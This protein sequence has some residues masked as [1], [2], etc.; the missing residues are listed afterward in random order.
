MYLKNLELKGF[1][2]YEKTE[3]L[4]SEGTNVFLGE[5]AQGKTNLMESIYFL[6][7]ARSHRT[8]KDKEL[9][10]WNQDFARV[11][12]EV[13]TRR[14][15]YPLNIVLS[16]KGK[17]AKLNHLEQKRLS[18]YIGHLN[19]ILFAPE[20]L[21]LVKGSPSVRRKFID[22]EMGQI[23]AIYLYHLTEYKKILKQRNEYLKQSK[24][25]KTFDSVYLDILTEQLATAG[26]EILEQRHTFTV[27]LENWARPIQE[28][29]SQSKEILTIH[30]LSP[31]DFNKTA[32]KED[33]YETLLSLYKKNQEREL[34]QGTTVIGPH[35]DDLQFFI[36]ERNVQTY[37]SQGQQ[38]TTAL[39]VK[40]A[41]IE[42]MQVMTGEYPVLLLDDVLSELD[43][44]RQTHLLKAIE[45][46][47]Q[48]F[49]TTTSLN[50]VKLDL[51]KAPQVFHVEEGSV[52]KIKDSSE[53]TTKESD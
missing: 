44:D 19:V 15:T 41:E 25:N 34:E 28:E 1:R 51:L 9:I 47:V 46:K 50:G 26:A 48:T 21:S 4:F 49:I 33:I 45:D 31:I 20:D 16:K 39:S 40:L 5:N 11:S 42:L 6:A 37:G 2:N 12:G 7:L 29:I 38:R 36:N 27:Q 43:D 52:K 8:S 14:T 22:M 13:K 3:V 35:R 10:G 23:S 24:Y 17:R 18:N 32:K 30:Y 53:E